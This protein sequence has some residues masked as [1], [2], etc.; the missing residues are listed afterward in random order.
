MSEKLRARNRLD[1]RAGPLSAWPP[2]RPSAWL[3]PP[4]AHLPFPLEEPRAHRFALGRVALLHGVRALGLSEGDE[5]LV[6]AYHHGSEIQAL[7]HV[8]GVPREIDREAVDDYLTFG[9][10]PSPRSAFTAI[11]KVPPANSASSIPA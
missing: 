4:T 6:P 8:P 11:R 2:L 9:Y 3:R 1:G 7:W 10:V 5:V